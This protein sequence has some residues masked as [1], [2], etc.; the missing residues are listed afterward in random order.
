MRVSFSH[1]STYRIF[2]SILVVTLVTFILL[3][4]AIIC[5]VTRFVLFCFHDLFEYL[6]VQFYTYFWIVTRM[7]ILLLLVFRKRFI[8]LLKHLFHI[9]KIEVVFFGSVPLQTF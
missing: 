5:F 3:S 2:V 8:A 6:G 9:L 4:I 7:N 1:M